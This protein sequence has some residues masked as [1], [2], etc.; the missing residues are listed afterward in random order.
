MQAASLRDALAIAEAEVA[1]PL[2]D[3][4]LPEPTAE[5]SRR[6][7]ASNTA[8]NDEGMA[9]AIGGRGLARVRLQK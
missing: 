9:A 4:D 2:Y 8:A 7:E 6:Q 1:I 3:G 5:G